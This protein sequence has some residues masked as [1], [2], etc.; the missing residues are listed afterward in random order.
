MV[1]K[2]LLH[3]PPRHTAH[4]SEEPQGEAPPSPP[5]PLSPSS[6]LPPPYPPRHHPSLPRLATPYNPPPSL[7]LMQLLRVYDDGHVEFIRFVWAKLDMHEKVKIGH[8]TDRLMLETHIA[9][10]SHRL[11]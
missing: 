11:A 1:S 6:P 3:L 2:E 9:S 8:P 7:P 5:P 4:P 10:L